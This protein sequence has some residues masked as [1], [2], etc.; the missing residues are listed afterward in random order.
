MMQEPCHPYPYFAAAL[1]Q[2]GDDPKT[3][4][5]A[6]GV[7]SRS[8]SIYLAGQGLPRVEVVKRHPPLDVA[9]TRDFATQPQP[10]RPPKRPRGRR[11]GQ[12]FKSRKKLSSSTP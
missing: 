7:S 12:A 11:P 9:L 6:L 5:A 4:G 1:R 8:V 2:Y 10:Q 3:I